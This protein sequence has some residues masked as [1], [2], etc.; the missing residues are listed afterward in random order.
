MINDLEKL[1]RAATPQNFDSA[2]EDIRSGDIVECPMCGGEGEV[3][4]TAD[5][6]NYDDV[7]I[8]VQF[9]G[10]GK[11][12]RSAEAYYRAAN[13]NTVLKLCEIIRRQHEVLFS[14]AK[15][16]QRERV[17][18]YGRSLDEW[19]SAEVDEVLDIGDELGVE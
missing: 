16:D 14:V 4:V 12:F 8:G 10:V 19:L 3:E 13:P 15:H 1:A 6:C 7:A 2:K 11:E 17:V 9:Y 5:Y 18:L